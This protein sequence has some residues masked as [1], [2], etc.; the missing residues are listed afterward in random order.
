MSGGIL[1]GGGIGF[2]PDLNPIVINESKTVIAQKSFSDGELSMFKGEIRDIELTKAEQLIDE[3]Y[4]AEYVVSVPEVGENDKDKYLHTNAETGEKEWIPV[5][6]GGGGLVMTETYSGGKY[7]L[8]K[9]ATEIKNALVAG[10]FVVATVGNTN[11]VILS[12]MED[13]E[14]HAFIFYGFNSGVA[15]TWT[16]ANGNTNPSRSS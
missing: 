7:T 8:N 5:E 9:K 12:Y 13:T 10:Q 15:K 16:A 14:D 6:A 4:V 3:G 11:S 2:I 1:N